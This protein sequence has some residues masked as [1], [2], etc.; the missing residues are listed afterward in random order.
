MTATPMCQGCGAP[1]TLTWVDLGLQPL[2]NSNVRPENAA[3]PDELYPLHARVCEAC[4]LVQ[5][6]SVVP[7]SDIFNDDYA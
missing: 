1:L 4:L 6:D 2:S 3:T 5:V 7:A